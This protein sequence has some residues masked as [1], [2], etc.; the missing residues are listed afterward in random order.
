[1]D[2]EHLAAVLCPADPL[3]RQTAGAIVPSSQIAEYLDA[4]AQ[5]HGLKW[6]AA[7]N[8]IASRAANSRARIRAGRAAAC[9]VRLK[10]TGITVISCEGF[11]PR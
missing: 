3:N 1:M 11:S 2:T 4:F 6:E 5:A 8:S 9:Q 10:L 7:G